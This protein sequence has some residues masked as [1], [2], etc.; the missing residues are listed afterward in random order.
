[1]KKI[2]ITVNLEINIENSNI[3]HLTKQ[4]MCSLVTVFSDLVSQALL[5]YG[6]VYKESGELNEL[7]GLAEEDYLTWKSLNGQLQTRLITT[8]GKIK[9]PQL[10]IY[11]HSPNKKKRSKNITRLLLGVPSYQRIPCFVKEM[12]GMLSSLSSYRTAQSCIDILWNWKF[13]LGSFR[14]AVSWLSERVTLGSRCGGTTEFVADGTGISTLKTGKRGSELK[15]LAQW[16]LD[17]SLHVV[18]IGIGKYNSKAD[19]EVLFAPL[20]LVDEA[21]RKCLSVL[22][23]GCKS[24][25][26]GAQS[27]HK[28]IRIQRDIWH[29]CH[30]LKYYL[31][32]DKVSKE[33]KIA[34][35]KNVFKAVNLSWRRSKSDCLELLASIILFCDRQGY[36][37]CRGYLMGCAE[38]LFTHE[39]A[40][41]EHQNSSQIERM[42][43]T[44]NQRMD[45]GV[46]SDKGALAVCKIR[47]AYFYNGWRAAKTA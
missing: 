21:Q 9:I 26:A 19:W 41:L 45:I 17:G 15:I 23:D 6:A 31:W 20:L 5:H 25:L 4:F 38:H 13:G 34:L 22:M 30:Q 29:I 36:Q 18:S 37:H 42:M 14:R 16:L 32:K 46:W 8:F 27:V 28:R 3:L 12:M 24:I 10:Q 43:R 47:L 33:H 7:L 35:I 11:I 40:Q 2:K 44:V 1:M 39:E